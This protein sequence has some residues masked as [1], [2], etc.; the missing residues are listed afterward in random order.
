LDDFFLEGLATKYG[1]ASGSELG[2]DGRWQVE[3]VGQ[4]PFKTRLVVLRPTRPSHFNGTVLLVWNNVSGGFDAFGVG[5]PG[6][7][8]E[9]G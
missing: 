7:L 6:G 8:M 9:D 2:W 5:D 4:A 3:P 1:L